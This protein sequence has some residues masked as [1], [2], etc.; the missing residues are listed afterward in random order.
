MRTLKDRLRHTLLFEAL[1]LAI[2]A[3]GGG[4]IFDR[5]VEV[6][7]ALSLMFSVLA[8]LWNLLFNW[9]FDLWD[10]KYRGMAKRGFLV[11]ATHA[12]LF[13]TGMVIAG[14]FLIAWWLD[15]SYW[16]GFVMG[17]GLS[18]F[19]LV[20]AYL[21]NWAYDVIFPVPREDAVNP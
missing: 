2:V 13:E 10:R 14:I 11:R 6:M 5:P 21:Y 7:G 20:Y 12:T 15:V 4:W 8:M 9:L 16:D 3:F 18:L 1:A 17:I 19:F